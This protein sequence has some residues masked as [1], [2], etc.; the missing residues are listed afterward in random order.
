M[1]KGGGRL[2]N[3]GLPCPSYRK[4]RTKTGCFTC[5]KRKKKCDECYPV[6]SG[7]SRNFL[8]CIWPENKSDTLPRDFEIT[9]STAADL[10][11]QREDDDDADDYALVGSGDQPQALESTF[12]LQDRL[13]SRT[14]KMEASIDTIDYDVPVN[15]CSVIPL[16]SYTHT[17]SANVN[18]P[19]VVPESPDFILF[20]VQPSIPVA[21]KHSPFLSSSSS[22]SP[23]SIT[24]GRS[25]S[26]FPPLDESHSLVPSIDQQSVNQMFSSLYDTINSG[27][28]PWPLPVPETSIEETA[29]YQH[30]LQRFVP[31]SLGTVTGIPQARVSA[32]RE[33]F[34]AYGS[35]CMAK[36]YTCSGRHGGYYSDIADR[37]Y[38]RAIQLITDSRSIQHGKRPIDVSS[39]F[40][41]SSDWLVVCVR[42]MQLVYK[43]L[44]LV[45]EKCFENISSAMSQIHGGIHSCSVDEPE[46]SMLVSFLFNSS[47]GLYFLP[48]KDM[49]QLPSPFEIF[50]Q[51]REQFSSIL[52]ES[53]R[54]LHHEGSKD[55]SGWL[56]NV[57]LGS[58][59]NCFE[60]LCKLMWILRHAAFFD[61]REKTSYL[62]QVK[63]DMT[64]IWTTLQTS[65]IQLDAIPEHPNKSLLMFAKYLHQALEILHIKLTDPSIKSTNPV[66]SFYV[67]QFIHIYQ[68]VPSDSSSVTVSCLKL[69]PLF[70]AGC[71]AKILEHRVF[72]SKEL[73]FVARD[74]DL[75]FVENLVMELEDRWCIEESGG[76]SSF[77]S[78][79]NREGF[80][81]LCANS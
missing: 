71:A 29:M 60:N 40:V 54:S 76:A 43:S 49:L 12:L 35:S 39:S 33:I 52:F 48:A 11:A 55:N 53:E 59:F 75:P 37:H 68:S 16:T 13:H 44:D 10:Q 61:D 66:I 3:R 34:Y 1:S 69:M 24:S 79:V 41:A 17:I 65:E 77:D 32:L 45:S 42:A 27:K 36:R 2:A 31:P 80:Q 74:L 14:G 26:M 46:S 78:L 56:C 70:I 21:S 15:M 18:V 51:N 8:C 63:R 28:L 57:I 20:K 19:K 23:S 22:S 30:F 81:E 72:I 50:P 25:I 67:G 38:R 4:T 47:T 62:G 64:I 5:R 58:V 73:Y 7:C 6:C 9:S